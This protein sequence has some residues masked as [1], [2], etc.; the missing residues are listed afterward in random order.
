MSNLLTTIYSLVFTVVLADSDAALKGEE[1]CFFAAPLISERIQ[2]VLCNQPFLVSLVAIFTVLSMVVTAVAAF[3]GNLQ[4]ITDNLQKII[5]FFKKNLTRKKAEVD[6]VELLKY[7][8]QLLPIL[9]SNILS[10]QKNSLHELIQIDIKKEEQ[11]QQ[12]GGSDYNLVPQDKAEKDINLL[13]RI[14]RVFRNQDNQE[15]ELK[16]K[17]K[18]I[19]FYDRKDIQGKLLILGDPGAGKTTELICLAKDL[20]ARAIDDET[21]SIP[22]IFELSSWQENISIADWLVEQLP[23]K[24]PGLPKAVAKKW[25][26]NRQLIPLLDGLDELG[27]THENKCIVAIN[28]FMQ[29]RFQPALVVCC[30]LEEYEQAQTQLNCLNGAIYLRPLSDVQ[31]QNYLNRLRRSSIWNKTI[32]NEPSILEL[33]RKPLFLTMI[34]VAYQ[35]RAIRNKSE[36]FEAYIEKQLNNPDN[37]GEYPP[38]KSPSPKQTLHYL[39]WLARKLE[40][41]QETEF[42]IEGIQPSWLESS[43]QIIIYRLMGVL[44]G[45]VIGGLIVGVIVWFIVGVIGGF[46]Y[47]LIGAFI[48][49]LAVG[50]IGRLEIE[51]VE[52]FSINVHDIKLKERLGV[53]LIVGMGGGLTADIIFGM[54]RGLTKGVIVG[55]SDVLIEWLIIGVTVGILLGLSGAM[56]SSD[57][58]NKYCANQGIWNSLKNG[59]IYGGLI[60]GL[61]FGLIFG[62]IYGGL[63][64]GLIFGLIYGL[65]FGLNFGLKS[66]IRHFILRIIL[67]RNGN[68]PWNYAKFL[69]HAVKHRFI[70]RVGGRYRF[71][72]DLLR[73]H[74]AQ[75]PLN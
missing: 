58:E 4:K 40:V 66:V 71:M 5:D 13:N 20:I 67:Y 68:I 64:G 52:K 15:T 22:V 3:T 21:A 16:P 35:D 28:E 37:Q 44:A 62:L 57:V 39:A 19:N 2:N 65:I 33:V 8:K 14:F 55:I 30:R 53:G 36:L 49:G 25:L 56:C 27:L 73:K 54:I 69:E 51:S 60:G 17:Q 42:L 48:G 63:I 46:I 7:R 59:L 11:R 75:M 10:R 45:G 43:N 61:I 23:K 6:E 29:S 74:F 38:H 34:I 26:D 32:V 24:Y 70:Q 31:I 50:V 18:I 72:H 1:G 47:G 41:E 9:Q 12:V